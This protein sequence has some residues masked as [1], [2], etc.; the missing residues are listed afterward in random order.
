MKVYKLGDIG[1]KGEYYQGMIYEILKKKWER[2]RKKGRGSK[3]YTKEC[4]WASL[5]EH[6]S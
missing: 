2:E 5:R 4:V 3:W 1:E 6:S